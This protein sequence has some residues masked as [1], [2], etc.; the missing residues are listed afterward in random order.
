MIHSIKLVDVKATQIINAK[1]L[2]RIC[3]AVKCASKRGR[4]SVFIEDEFLTRAEMSYLALYGYRANKG[5]G[6]IYISWGK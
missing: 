4:T 6:Y 2:V 1:K 3:E 5:E